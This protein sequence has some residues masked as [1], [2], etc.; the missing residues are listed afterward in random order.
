VVVVPHVLHF[1][2]RFADHEVVVFSLQLVLLID[3]SKKE[4]VVELGFVVRL[5][6]NL[7]VVVV[8]FNQQVVERAV[9]G[10]NDHVLVDIFGVNGK[11]QVLASLFFLDRSLDVRGT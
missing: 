6:L 11:S 4:E 3:K 10:L 8:L 7:L 2:E 1:L 9:L 5:E